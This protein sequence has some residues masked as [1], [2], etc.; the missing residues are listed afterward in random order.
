MDEKLHHKI[1][2]TSDCLSEQTMFD[3]ID[4]KLLPK[5]CHLVEKHLLHCELCADA[6]EGLELFKNRNKIAFINQKIN[7]SLILLNKKE[8]KVFS[9]NYKVI[10]SIAAGLLLLI[11]GTFFFHQYADKEM[12]RNHFA[13][14]TQTP[15]P[16]NTP[17]ATPEEK[18]PADSKQTISSTEE[19]KGKKLEPEKSEQQSR[20][21]ISKDKKSQTDNTPK[22]S[23]S[24]TKLEDNLYKSSQK[25][26]DEVKNA[27]NAPIVATGS[28]TT[29]HETEKEIK[30]EDSKEESK[31]ENKPTVSFNQ[32]STIV[33]TT[34]Q[35][36]NEVETKSSKKRANSSVY[37][38]RY[39]DD[40]GT[41][42]GDVTKEAN[43]KVAG[44]G[45]LTNPARADSTQMDADRRENTIAY[46]PVTTVVSEIKS[47]DSEVATAP[48]KNKMAGD[49]VSFVPANLDTPSFP[50]GGTL[51]LKFVHD[52]FNYAV[53]NFKNGDGTKITMQ[54]TVDST[55]K[56][57]NSKII[58][59]INTDFNNEALRVVSIMP[60]WIP[61][62]KNGK[63]V[64][65]NYILPIQMEIKNAD[66]SK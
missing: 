42:K 43:Q 44:K 31:A 15:P 4:N 30:T 11:G 62:Q 6:I 1:F 55:G 27:E 24:E 52:N 51:L 25:K 36:N 23:N 8:G 26:A 35:N 53:S 41:K 47:Q 22:L 16:P 54:I 28:T 57:I 34:T 17:T 63:P 14:L 65:S 20:S 39:S 64:S 19:K 33:N 18:I 45:N 12:K 10:S 40:T 50:G 29:L 59:G 9:I 49:S 2:T 46:A 61:A 66:H 60:K 5:E 7:E 3:Y 38:S 37:N 58:K 21:G 13:E 48:M 32:T 56:I